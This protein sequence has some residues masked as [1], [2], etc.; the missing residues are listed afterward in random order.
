VTHEF[1]KT[2]EAELSFARVRCP[3]DNALTERFYGMVKQKKLYLVGDYPDETSAREK[4]GLYI[5]FYNESRTHQAL[6][7]FTPANVHEANNTSVLLQQLNELKRRTRDKRSYWTE[8]SS[9]SQQSKEKECPGKGRGEIID[10]GTSGKEIFERR[11]QNFQI[12]E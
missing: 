7:I 11:Q 1:F 3:T 4:L 2:L 8:R 5:W 10:R 6:I 12:T 9:G